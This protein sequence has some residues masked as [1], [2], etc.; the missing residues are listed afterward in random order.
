MIYTS[1][2][3]RIFKMAAGNQKRGYNRLLFSLLLLPVISFEL[4]TASVV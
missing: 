2:S 4:V 1:E 3:V